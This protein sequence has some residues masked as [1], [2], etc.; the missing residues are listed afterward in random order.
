MNYSKIQLY[1]TKI[2]YFRRFIVAKKLIKVATVIGAILAVIFFYYAFKLHLFQNP[3]ALQK[4]IDQFGA[5]G[6]LVFILLQIIQPIVPIVPGGLSDV[7]GI[8][9][10]GN[11]LGL[12]YV[13]IGLVIGEVILFFLVRKYGMRF[14]KV[15]LSENSLK[16]LNLIVQ[17]GNK[18]IQKYIIIIFLMPFGPDDLVCL[19]AGFTDISF[20][21]YLT[22]IALLKP[23]SVGFH[24]F[25]MIHIF[26]VL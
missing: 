19:A 7:A 23:I 24:C 12:L 20:K 10:Y 4:F 13:C 8:L 21:K 5:Y 3:H 26:K 22:T 17:K 14:A 6:V 16:E 1:L 18:H 9:M 2:N 11:V 25:I 15:I